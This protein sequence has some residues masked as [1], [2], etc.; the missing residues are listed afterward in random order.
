MGRMTRNG[1]VFEFNPPGATD[2]DMWIYGLAAGPDGNISYATDSIGDA[3]PI[4]SFDP[5]NALLASGERVSAV[6]D[7]LDSVENSLAT[8]AD[9]SGKADASFYQATINWGDGTTSAG[10]IYDNEDG[11]FDVFGGAHVADRRV[12]HQHSHHRHSLSGWRFRGCRRANAHRFGDRYG[13]AASR[14]RDRRGH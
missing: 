2:Y 5:H 10:D 12:Q 9:L 4:G 1:D 7:A 11:T 3:S 8:F 13:A 6:A 14:T